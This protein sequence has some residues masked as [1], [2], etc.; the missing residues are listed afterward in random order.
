MVASAVEKVKARGKWKPELERIETFVCSEYQYT[1]EHQGPTSWSTEEG[2]EEDWGIARSRAVAELHSDP[3]RVALETKLSEL[4]GADYPSRFRLDN[5]AVSL[6]KASVPDTEALAVQ[7][8][9]DLSG[10]PTE[11]LIVAR[12]TGLVVLTEAIEL[13]IPG[14]QVIF[15][16]F[17]LELFV[18]PRRVSRYIPDPFFM[19][20]PTALVT[21]R[22]LALAP[23]EAQKV[24][25]RTKVIAALF[26]PCNLEIHDYTMS[27]S[28]FSGHSGTMTSGRS[29]Q[30]RRQLVLRTE[31]VPAFRKF[32]KQMWQ[33]FPYDPFA[34]KHENPATVSLGR[35]TEAC[36]EPRSA[37]YSMTTVMIGLEGLFTEGAPEISYRLRQR[38][39]NFLGHIGLNPHTIHATVREGYNIRSTL[40]HGGSLSYK[41][42]RRV[43]TAHGTLD[44]LLRRNLDLLRLSI[45]LW[46]MARL[47][48]DRIL[49]LLDES[50]FDSKRRDELAS[51]L[52]QYK[53]AVGRIPSWA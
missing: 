9:H 24:L 33:A 7:L 47:E 52:G 50:M 10:K 53:G 25:E 36:T 45:I 44:N 35:Y 11:Q 17:T 27:S 28:G 37:E 15:E 6:M 5:L 32:W 19:D 43:E 42:R 49:D 41:E 51:L 20:F 23:V 3:A 31:D 13:E 12:T 14:G 4:G 2:V 1:Q 18:K 46:F 26:E 22:V 48:K 16:P 34:P 38:L 39:S 40:V 21:V 8:L 30:A 29:A